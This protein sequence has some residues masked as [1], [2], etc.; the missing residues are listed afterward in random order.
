M[1]NTEH[2]GVSRK[3][4][5][6]AKD[7][8][9]GARGR[10]AEGIRQDHLSAEPQGKE[11]ARWTD[12]LGQE[13]MSIPRRGC[14]VFRGG[15]DGCC[16]GH[17]LGWARWDGKLGQDLASIPWGWSWRRSLDAILQEFGN[18][19]IPATFRGW[20]GEKVNLGLLSLSGRWGF[21]MPARQGEGS[22][23]VH[24]RRENGPQQG[25][26]EAWRQPGGR[27]GFGF[28]GKNMNSVLKVLGN[29]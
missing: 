5:V 11:R 27:K 28:L 4:V 29:P 10:E 8:V 26:V 12:R 13:H 25:S 1:N 17:E 7:K 24:V 16:S 14:C 18:W 3:Q 15:N 9:L 6:H 23:A 19:G 21:G 2:S 22:A 20:G